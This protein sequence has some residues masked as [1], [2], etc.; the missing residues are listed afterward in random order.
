[1]NNVH[2]S[3]PLEVEEILA[4]IYRMSTNSLLLAFLCL[5]FL[6]ESWQFVFIY[7]QIDINQKLL[8]TVVEAQ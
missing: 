4:T 6:P 1:M 7:S 3:N 5:F 2:I 8:V